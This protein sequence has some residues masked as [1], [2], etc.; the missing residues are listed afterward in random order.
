MNPEA[1]AREQ[2]VAKLRS[3]AAALGEGRG[4]GEEVS[5][6]SLGVH[7]NQAANEIEELGKKR[8]ASQAALSARLQRMLMTTLIE[9]CQSECNGYEPQIS[10]GPIYDGRAYV[11]PI[12]A[13]VQLLGIGSDALDDPPP[14]RLAVRLDVSLKA[15]DA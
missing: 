11:F 12:T 4:L 2:Q 13:K 7:L 14:P 3:M 1:E 5:P 9:F 8:L 10:V 15:T 6:R